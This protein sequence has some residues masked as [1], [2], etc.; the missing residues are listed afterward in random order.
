MKQVLL[1]ISEVPAEENLP[2]GAL[3]I[4]VDIP[5]TLHH[6]SELE[7]GMAVTLRDNVMLKLAELI[8]PEGSDE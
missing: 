7:E 1:T 8:T 5:P 3:S 2:N 4:K 6:A